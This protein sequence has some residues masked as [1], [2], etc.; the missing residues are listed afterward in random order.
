MTEEYAPQLLANVWL[1]IHNN[2]EKNRRLGIY[3]QSSQVL[4]KVLLD[5]PRHRLYN[6]ANAVDSST[7]RRNE[8]IFGEGHYK[9]QMR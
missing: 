9:C 2:D 8:I 4:Q 3:S 7:N 6:N 5:L 1:I